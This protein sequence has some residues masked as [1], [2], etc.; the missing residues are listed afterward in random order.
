M[1]K[2]IISI[3]LCR[4]VLHTQNGPTLLWSSWS[5]LSGFLSL[6]LSSE[7]SYCFS[8]PS[9]CLLLLF[10]HPYSTCNL[11]SVITGFLNLNNWILSTNKIA[12]GTLIK[13]TNNSR[14]VE[15]VA[16]RGMFLLSSCLAPRR[17]SG[18]MSPFLSYPC[19]SI[20]VCSLISTSV[21]N[22]I[23]EFLLMHKTD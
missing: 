23:W 16:G 5:I 21:G 3:Q 4:T 18:N 19:L 9:A 1:R 6:A 2:V 10:S 17:Y 20:T 12:H 15:I 7:F 14:T 11:L 13:G 8:L 22:L